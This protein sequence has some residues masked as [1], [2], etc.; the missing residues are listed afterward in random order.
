MIRA[1]AG[2]SSTIAA[3]VMIA[4]TGCTSDSPAEEESGEP[5]IGTI[6]VV[7]SSADLVLPLDAYDQTADQEHAVTNAVNILGRECMRR[8]DLAWPANQVSDAVKA[9]PHARRYAIIDEEKAAVEGYHAV[10]IIEQQQAIAEEDAAAPKPPREAMNVWVGRGQTTYNG[11][12]VPSGG[13]AQ[14]ALRQL[15]DGLA[16]V[17]LRLVERLRIEARDRTMTDSRVVAVFA[18]WSACMKKKGYAYPDPFAANDDQR[19]QVEKITQAETDTAVADVT[20]K[21]EA[22]VVG[23]MLVVERAYQQRQIERHAA[24]LDA[25]RN[26]VKTRV[27]NAGRVLA[28]GGA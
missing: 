20:C 17:D 27:A 23:T 25:V 7:R 13:C 15:S 18:R 1:H 22:N 12:P 24:E 14:E 28:G 26:Y 6:P 8:F 2:F 21:K 11:Q 9:D 4:I 3:V 10:D 16:E 5:E 19:W